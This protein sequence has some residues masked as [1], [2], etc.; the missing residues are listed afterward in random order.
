MGL[1]LSN[2]ERDRFAS[3]LRLEAE[4]AEGMAE[5]IKKLPGP[6]MEVLAKKY[7]TE[8]L[9]CRVVEKILTSGETME[10]SRKE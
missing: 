2:Q 5:Q 3:F 10:I 8:A 1:L 6:M 7:R 4:T 9:A